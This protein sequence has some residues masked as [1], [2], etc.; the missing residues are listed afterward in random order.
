MSYRNKTYI[1]FDAD[2]DIHYYRLMTAWKSRDKIDFNFFDAHDLNNLW[3][4]S[5]EATIRQS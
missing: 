5:S 4:K 3:G 2:T 1:I